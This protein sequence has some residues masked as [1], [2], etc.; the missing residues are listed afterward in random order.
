M[1]SLKSIYY[2]SL[3]A[4]SLII[5][6]LGSPAANAG[7]SEEDIKLLQ[8]AGE[9]H[10]QKCAAGQYSAVV[11]KQKLEESYSG[12]GKFAISARIKNTSTCEAVLSA[13]IRYYDCDSNNDCDLIEEQYLPEPWIKRADKHRV[14]Y[15]NRTETLTGSI[16]IPSEKIFGQLM[17]TVEAYARKP[18]Y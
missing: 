17:Y 5:V 7:L 12:S 10:R 2:F 15:V 18:V 9:R 6:S 4:L 14:V 8:G 3:T 11:T 1:L 16:I 13:H